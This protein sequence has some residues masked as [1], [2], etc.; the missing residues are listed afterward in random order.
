M[1]T[2]TALT[3]NS[4]SE[5]CFC[6]RRDGQRPSSTKGRCSPGKERTTSKQRR[7]D[8][9]LVISIVAQLK[10][11]FIRWWPIATDPLALD[12]FGTAKRSSERYPK[13]AGRG[14]TGIRAPTAEGSSRLTLTLPFCD[15][16][17]GSHRRCKRFP[18]LTLVQMTVIGASLKCRPR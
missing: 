9:S 4:D 18:Q 14:D 5:R 16:R 17:A 15:A 11:H 7:P 13:R 6:C 2:L 12:G 1:K 8:G 3:S 10:R